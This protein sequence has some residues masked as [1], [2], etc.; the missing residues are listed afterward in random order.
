MDSTEMLP[1]GTLLSNRYHITRYLA[2]GGFGNT[3]EAVDTHFNSRVAVKEFFM[4]GTN[5]RAADHTTVVVSNVVNSNSFQAQLDKFRREAHRLFTLHHEHIV[6]VSDLFDCHG[7]SYYVMELI[8]G[9]SLADKVKRGPLRENEVREVARQLFSALDAVHGAGLYH[10]DIKPGNIMIDAKGK[11][12]LIDF[13]A[14]KQMSAM[15][16]TSLSAS[17]MAFTPGYAPIEQ[18]GQRT[19]SIGPWTDFY[20]I[21][22]TLF[23]LLT[24]QRPPEIDPDDTADDSRMFSYPAGTS[25]QMQRAISRM[26]NPSPRKRPQNVDEMRA[27]LNE[28]PISGGDT[29]TQVLDVHV[30]ETVPPVIKPQTNK[31]RWIGGGI[32]VGLLVVIGI[33]LAIS[34]KSHQDTYPIAESEGTNPYE[35]PTS[36][37]SNRQERGDTGEESAAATASDGLTFAVN[38]VVFQMIPVKGGKFT[39]GATDEQIEPDEDEFPPHAVNIRD[40]YIGKTEVTQALWYAVTG[41]NPSEFRGDDKPVE[42]ITWNDCQTFIRRLNEAT[43][44]Q[45]PQGHSFR[46]P[47]EAEW[48]YAARGGNQSLDQVF[49]GGNYLPS[50]S[51]YGHGATLGDHQGNSREQ[52]H[53]VAQKEPNELGLFDMSGNVWEC[54]QDG[55]DKDYYQRSPTSDPCN[56]TGSKEHVL[57]GGAWN[58]SENGCR[59]SNRIGYD[60]SLKA[61]FFGLRLAL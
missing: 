26:M 58:C 55:Y 6:K 17:G 36:S 42:S 8:D 24:A 32:A 46:L 39:M 40:F 22:A 13:G 30:E 15:E 48:E 4:R 5:H 12:T 49:A 16:R 60:T 3:Y 34:N 50:V 18:E 38:G 31:I 61:N 1:I 57:R 41:N 20:A 44:G 53:A 14:S 29:H 45:R 11:C 33:I 47:T 21:G 37:S 27:L 7:T 43:E 51:W 28:S 9:E 2:S 56:R 52:T 23:N 54:C 35:S 59:V 10:L 25:R 19:K